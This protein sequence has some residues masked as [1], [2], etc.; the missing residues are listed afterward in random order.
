MRLEARTSFLLAA[1]MC[2]SGCVDLEDR[3]EIVTL[4]VCKPSHVSTVAC[5]IDGDTVDLDDCGDD[6]GTRVRLLGTAA[7][8]IAHGAEPAEC[9]GDEAHDFL[10]GLLAGRRVEVQYDVEGS[11]EDAFERTL[12][13]LILEVDASDPLVDDL[14]EVELI[15]EDD[16][17]PY[18]ILVNELLIRLGYATVYRG[19]VAQDVRYDEALEAAEEA[20]E[21][22]GLGLWE[23]CDDD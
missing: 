12:A 20:A 7:P 18:E 16:E 17:A 14:V 10:D 4:E 21:R 19:D 3:V 6:V 13:W 1:A 2:A 23:A 9:F 11:C 22:E 5:T 15:E 8:E